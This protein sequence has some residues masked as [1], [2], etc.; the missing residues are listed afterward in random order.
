MSPA[1]RLIAS[2]LRALTR[3]FFREIQVTGL[4]HVPETGGGLIV[5]WHPNALVDPGLILTQ[6]PRH[7]VFGARHGLFKLPLFGWL[8]RVM[9]AVPIYRRIDAEKGTDPGTRQAANRQSLDA[10]AR[11]VAN[12]SFAALFPE[13]ISHD[14]PDVQALKT[15]VASLY[16]RAYELTPESDSPPVILPVGLHYDEKGVFGSNV[17][18]AF[19][20]PLELTPEIA[21]P[22]VA[23]APKEARRAQYQKLTSEVDRVLHKIIY[24]TESW[25]LHHLMQR[26]RKL[27][28]AERAARA[29]AM[30]GKPDMVE[31]I[32][33]FARFWTGYNALL[34]T[35]PKETQEIINRTKCYDE[36]LRSLH[37]QDHEL[38]G[39]PPLTSLWLPLF[40]VL[41]ALFV[42]LVLP[43]ILLIGY[44][45]N[46]PTALLLLALSKLSA[47]AYKDEASF[48]LLVGALAFPLTWLLVAVLVGWGQ[49]LLHTAYPQIPNAPLLTGILAFFLSALGGIVA[50]QYLRLARETA[51]AI[52][53]RLTRARRANTIDRLLKERSEIYEQV[54]GM[55]QGL[56]LP[57]I[58]AAD[59][60]ILQEGESI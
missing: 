23:D 16:Y 21:R 22:P 2:F 20:P 39:S 49:S 4:E 46:L 60:R 44:I 43:P 27:V 14:E 40:I 30:P 19:H 6:L 36:E 12:G 18:V 56:D 58:V 11:A 48:K 7:V 47:K 9:G 8:M 37:L 26:A 51:R 50:L 45:A 29:A 1:Y 52:R 3:I 41:Q 5:A 25:Q 55:A 24:G 15:G 13:G 10:L 17:L 59:G 35:R 34:S 28:R 54:M 38:D 31:K 42:Y 32:L 57:G 33:G 53:V